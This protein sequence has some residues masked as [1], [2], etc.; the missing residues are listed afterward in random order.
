MGQ[1]EILAVMGDVTG[2]LPLQDVLIDAVAVD[3]A[4]EDAIAIFVGPVVAEIDHAAGVG[5]AAAGARCASPLPPRESVQ[6]P[7]AQ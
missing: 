1:Q 6:L 5:M 2:A 3:V 7:P 4:H